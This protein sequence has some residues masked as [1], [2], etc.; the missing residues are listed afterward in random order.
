VCSGEFGLLRSERESV[1]K[2]RK[3]EG[4]GDVDA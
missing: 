3:K 2:G 1:K 4:E